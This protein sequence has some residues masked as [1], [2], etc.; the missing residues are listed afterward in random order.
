MQ[1]HFHNAYFVSEP[2]FLPR[3]I[4]NMVGNKRRISDLYEK[5]IEKFAGW[6]EARPDVRGA[7]I[8]GSRARTDHAAD[9]WADLDVLIAT[10]NPE[11]YAKTSEWIKE[12]GR[13]I[14][15][16]VEETSGGNEQE[17]RVLYEGMLDVDYA[18]FPIA[19]IKQFLTLNNAETALR[20]AN[21]FGRG[22]RVVLDK[23]GL[24][25]NLE[26]MVASLKQPTPKPL[27]QDEFTQVVSDFLFHCVWTAKHVL[28]GELWWALTCLNCHLAQLQLRMTEWQAR[29]SHRR[30]SDTWFRGRFLEEWAD[31]EVVEG[32]KSASSH[33]DR[34]DAIAALEA[35]M[36]L[37][38][39]TSIKTANELSLHYPSDTDEKITRW[40]RS[41][42]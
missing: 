23:D 20:M 27:T 4:A 29:A 25:K 39:E 36:K 37:F 16:F 30:G 14:L 28:R 24:T 41:R 6:A 2:N 18:I 12:M 13:P 1:T 34:Q 8:I 22:F 5:L 19:K 15:T 40:I 10:T 9:E 31:P 26:D 38:R 42:F 32:L 11:H 33:Y 21:A 3:G 7:V 35:S 17:R